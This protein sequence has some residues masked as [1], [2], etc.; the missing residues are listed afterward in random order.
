MEAVTLKGI[1]AELRI[2]RAEN[3]PK[4]AKGHNRVS[5]GNGRKAHPPRRK[6]GRRSRPDWIRSTAPNNANRVR[7]HSQCCQM[8]MSLRVS[9]QPCGA[10]LLGRL[11][12][13]KFVYP[14]SGNV[15]GYQRFRAIASI[16]A[17]IGR[18]I[19]LTQAPGSAL[20]H[21]NLLLHGSTPLPWLPP[22]S[23]R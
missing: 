1:C 22:S 10:G 6:R 3:V 16:R 2:S 19:S 12:I 11:N 13:A 5:H 9:W 21:G 8:P 20:G 18:F 15:E 14:G 4:L 23:F 7:W 17:P